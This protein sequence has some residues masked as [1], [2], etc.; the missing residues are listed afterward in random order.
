VLYAENVISPAEAKGILTIAESRME[1]SAVKLKDADIG[2]QSSEW[3]TSSTTFLPQNSGVMLNVSSRVAALTRTPRGH[4]ETGLQVLRYDEGEYYVSHHDFFD[5]KDYR[6]DPYVL[7][8]IDRGKRNRQLTALYYMSDT[9]G[10]HTIFP[11]ADGLPMPPTFADCE[12]GLKV[13][14]KLGAL[15]IFYNLLASG[16]ADHMALH[17]A[18][19]PRDGTTKWAANNWIWNAPKVV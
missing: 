1:K 6:K 15:V 5:P 4:Q 12:Q 7:N 19:P 17:G 3:R 14:P 10:G 8:L 18:C 16:D 13:Y 11:R 2:K 9:S